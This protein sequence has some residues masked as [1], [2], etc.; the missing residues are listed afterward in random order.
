M[1]VLPS[2]TIPSGNRLAVRQNDP[3][4]TS[5]V[6]VPSTYGN[7]D[8]SPHPGVVAGIVLGSVAGFLLLL[9]LVYV[10]LHRGPVVMVEESGAPMSSVTGGDSSTF[11]S[12]SVI[13][14]KSKRGRKSRRPRS[15]GSR[16]TTR[17]KA[18]T[19]RSRE[20]SRRRV[21]PVIVDPPARERIIVEPPSLTP[22][23]LSS[24]PPHPRFAQESAVSGLSSDNEI[25]VEEEHSPSPP[26]R[27]YSQRYS[28]ER[29]RRE[30]YRDDGYRD[31]PPRDYSPR[32]ESRRY[33]RDR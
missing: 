30:S 33:S 5:F 29:Y 20:R 15:N 26:R 7:L 25:V 27:S 23:P 1:P 24:A 11:A 6:P 18:T 14:F 13:T 2:R 19:V 22:S 21:S 8:N 32:R 4:S 16:R 12:R 28:Q 31:Y 17:S 10:I 3:S 9:W